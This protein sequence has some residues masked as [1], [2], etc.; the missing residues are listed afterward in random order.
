MQIATIGN[1]V[2]ALPGATLPDPL[3]DA[4]RVRRAGKRVHPLLAGGTV[5]GPLYIARQFAWINKSLKTIARDLRELVD[6]HGFPAPAPRR[7][8]GVLL[9]G[10]AA[11][12]ESSL[13]TRN[14]V[15]AWFENGTP[16]SLGGVIDAARAR[17]VDATVND[18]IAGLGAER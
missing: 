4:E 17:H 13:W 3:P 1:G 7:Y 5:V 18:R 11:V 10:A 16:P 2:H 15:D 6:K 9:V 12:C 8:N 14:L